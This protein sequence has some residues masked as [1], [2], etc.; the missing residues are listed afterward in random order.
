MK[1]SDQ[2][3][4]CETQDRLLILVDGYLKCMQNDRGYAKLNIE[5]SKMK[6]I[7]RPYNLHGMILGNLGAS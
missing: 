5:K 6:G 3:L 1:I 4:G 2:T 7:D